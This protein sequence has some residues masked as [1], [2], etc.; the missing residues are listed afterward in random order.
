M[1]RSRIFKGANMSFN[2]IRENKI[3][4]KIYEFTEV[5]AFV[6]RIYVISQINR[7][8]GINTFL[9]LNQN[10]CCGKQ[11]NQVSAAVLLHLEKL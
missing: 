9:F 5:W 6:Y 7:Q 4:A 3:L 10:I 11:E 2:A 8:E 1:P